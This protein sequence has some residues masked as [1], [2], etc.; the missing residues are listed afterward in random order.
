MCSSDLEIDHMEI[1][2][3]DHYYSKRAVYGASNE[4]LT[5]EVPFQ[6]LSNRHRLTIFFALIGRNILN[7]WDAFLLILLLIP[8]AVIYERARGEAK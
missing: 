7:P 6:P 4:H 1:T 3:I 2:S 8:G 5:A